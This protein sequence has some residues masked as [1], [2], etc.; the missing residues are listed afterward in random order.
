[1][2][3]ARFETLHEVRLGYEL[4]NGRHGLPA[5][6]QEPRFLRMT[7]NPFLVPADIARRAC[8]RLFDPDIATS[9]LSRSMFARLNKTS[10]SVPLFISTGDPGA[11]FLWTKP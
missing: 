5:S 8:E 6:T 4:V 11:A 3:V 10:G 2:R 7:C 1:M 9:A